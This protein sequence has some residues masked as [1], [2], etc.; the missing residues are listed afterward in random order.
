MKIE[1]GKFY[2]TR[3]GRKVGP[4]RHDFGSIWDCKEMFPNDS[5]YHWTEDGC[6]GCAT[7]LDCP[8]LIAEWTDVPDY[9]DGKWHGWNGGECPVDPLARVE[10][11]LRDCTQRH[12]GTMCAAC[13][14]AWYHDE[15]PSD[16]IAFRVTKPAPPKSREWWVAGGNYLW[17]TYTEAYNAC[18]RG[19]K[20][21][22]VIE[23]PT[24]AT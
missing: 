9:N 4:M 16:I 17:D 18:E 20:P 23:K 5:D 14:T 6:R 1:E 8:N 22:H 19:E 2:R 24:E 3:D 7:N 12:D 11:R 15:T 21:I 13:E 10:I